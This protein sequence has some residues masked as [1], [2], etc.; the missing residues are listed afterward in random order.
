MT[1]GAAHLLSCSGGTV[2]VPMDVPIRDIN[3]Y[4][5]GKDLPQGDRPAGV[6]GFGSGKPVWGREA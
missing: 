4:M 5:G 6:S 1:H 2:Y 3:N